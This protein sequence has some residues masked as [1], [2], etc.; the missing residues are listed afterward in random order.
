MARTAASVKR[1]L[2]IPRQP[3]FLIDNLGFGVRPDRGNL[4]RMLG[5]LWSLPADIIDRIIETFIDMM[6][7]VE[8]RV[9]Q[10]RRL[11]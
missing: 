5:P 7:G 2:I 6:Q 9:L 11:Q 10:R 4:W 3:R 8:A 1:K